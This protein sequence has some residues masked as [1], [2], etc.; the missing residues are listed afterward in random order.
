MV[1]TKRLFPLAL[2]IPRGPD[3]LREVASNDARARISLDCL[4]VPQ[5]RDLVP[6]TL[7]RI[8]FEWCDR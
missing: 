3:V 6:L 8:E 4:H 1:T 2:S 5:S 7:F